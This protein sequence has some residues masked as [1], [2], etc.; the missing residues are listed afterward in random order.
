MSFFLEVEF[1]R[2]WDL[3]NYLRVRDKVTKIGTSKIK[4]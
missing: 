2:D 4:F 3:E 1:E